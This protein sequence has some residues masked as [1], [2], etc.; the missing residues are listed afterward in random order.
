MGFTSRRTRPV[1]KYGRADAKLRFQE[2][3]RVLDR[4]ARRASGALGPFELS[5]LTVDDMQLVGRDDIH[6]SPLPERFDHGPRLGLD[7]SE[8]G[9][10]GFPIRRNRIGKRDVGDER[11]NDDASRRFQIRVNRVDLR[12]D[13]RSIAN[14]KN[15]RQHGDAGVRRFVARRGTFIGDC[16][17]CSRGQKQLK[18]PFELRGAGRI[19]SVESRHKM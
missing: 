5:P 9:L 4:L 1:R 12:N 14:E 15:V 13:F 19:R 2:R 18:Q 7:H 10:S 3:R 6:A 11:I 16:R 8:R 17:P